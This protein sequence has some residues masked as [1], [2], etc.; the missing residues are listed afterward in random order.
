MGRS[1][2]GRQDQAGVRL[3]RSRGGYLREFA[4]TVFPGRRYRYLSNIQF[5]GLPPQA[6]SFHQ[7]L[8]GAC[9]QLF[10]ILSELPVEARIV[11]RVHAALE[12]FVSSD[13]SKNRA[14]I[15][16]VRRKQQQGRT[17]RPTIGQ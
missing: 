3:I 8:Q 5:R 9:F 16:T 13:R 11:I 15:V 1:G 12:G 10:G 2:P 7:Q 17:A 4:S 14:A 6:E